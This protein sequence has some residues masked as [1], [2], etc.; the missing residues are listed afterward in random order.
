MFFV[1]YCMT[2]LYALLVLL[3]TMLVTTIT[4]LYDLSY[5]I[6][7]FIL[8]NILH[9]SNMLHCS[10]TNTCILYRKQ[11]Y[12]AISPA[13]MICILIYWYVNQM[14]RYL[15][16]SNHYIIYLLLLWV[17]FLKINMFCVTWVIVLWYV[18]WKKH[19]YILSDPYLE[20]SVPRNECIHILI[21]LNP[22]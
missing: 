16:S 14:H 12:R 21:T 22:Y 15:T 8:Y 4:S 20:F 5:I 17:I 7:Y 3:V 10:I 19:V 11:P 2:I 13:K 6:I 1:F 18:L 9:P